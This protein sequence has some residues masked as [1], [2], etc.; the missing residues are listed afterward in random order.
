MKIFP[1]AIN[2][3]NVTERKN[4]FLPVEQLN[5]ISRRTGNVLWEPITGNED[6]VLIKVGEIL[7]NVKSFSRERPI[8]THNHT[9]ENSPLSP[10]DAALAFM[11][12]C[13]QMRATD[14]SKTVHIMELP[15]KIVSADVEKARELAERFNEEIQKVHFSEVLGKMREAFERKFPGLRFRDEK[16]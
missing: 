1:N 12:R 15:Q 3:L 7:R 11:M 4:L 2:T 13:L 16:L 5:V 9:E 10:K 6:E 8:A 14:R